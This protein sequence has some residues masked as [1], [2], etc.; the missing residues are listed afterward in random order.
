M[1]DAKETRFKL[2][3]RLLNQY[4]VGLSRKE[5]QKISTPK[6]RRWVKELE[7]NDK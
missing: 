1:T 4:D 7:E 5:L 2:V 6:I 3:G